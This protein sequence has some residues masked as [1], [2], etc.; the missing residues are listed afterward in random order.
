[1]N[2]RYRKATNLTDMP[3]FPLPEKH[4]TYI[5]KSLI[6]ECK[7]N[8]F[9]D[10]EIGWL[11]LYGSWCSALMF[12][13]I[14]PMTPAHKRFIIVAKKIRTPHR[15][16]PHEKLWLK[17]LDK[18]RVSGVQRKLVQSDQE[19]LQSLYFLANCFDDEL[20]EGLISPEYHNSSFEFS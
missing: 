6:W 16:L 7:I 13:L 12:G 2:C 10:G 20:S 3:L 1:M 4:L 8:D 5:G 14:D 17:Y 18:S 11:S 9:L 15:L 19:R